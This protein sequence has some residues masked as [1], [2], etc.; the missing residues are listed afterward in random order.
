[1]EVPLL[2]QIPIEISLRESGDQGC[3]YV[4]KYKDSQTAKEFIKVAEEVH[5]KCSETV[6]S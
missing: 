6:V 1:M 4:E 3:P 2:G 5:I